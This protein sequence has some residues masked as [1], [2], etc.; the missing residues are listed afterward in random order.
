MKTRIISIAFAALAI[1]G[2]QCRNYKLS[3]N[4]GFAEGTMYMILG[5]EAID[6]VAVVDSAFTFEGDASTPQHVYVADSTNL[7][8]ANYVCQ[9]FVEPGNIV[10]T[11]EEGKY[12]T[13]SGTVSNDARI[14]FNKKVEAIDEAYTLAEEA[15]AE[16]SVL[17]SIQNSY[18]ELQKEVVKENSDNLFGVAALLRLSYGDM[19]PKEIQGVLKT[20]P[21]GV[22]NSRIY[23]KLKEANE[24]ALLTAAGELYLE[25]GQT[26][27]QGDTLYVKNVIEDPANKYVLI[28]FW[29]SWCCPCMGEV[30]YLVETY[31]EYHDKGFEIFG[32]SLDNSR[33]AWLNAVESNG[34]NWIHVSDLQG[35]KNAAAGVYGVNSI[36]ANYLIECESGRI[37]ATSLRGE[38]LK[39][40]IAELL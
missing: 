33:D 21:K 15:G 25:F 12:P 2:C 18:V 20:F 10:L 5:G 24:K 36:P 37:V 9:V 28:D 7:Y 19:E 13:A 14:A 38:E 26:D 39:A 40:K 16:E 32:V 34:M 30:P 22:R 8:A 3:G 4:A 35:W 6:S 17:D 29:A 1:C 31:A 11:K 27:A 23:T